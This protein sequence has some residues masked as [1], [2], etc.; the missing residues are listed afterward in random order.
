MQA[1]AAAATKKCGPGEIS[2]KGYT[3]K[4][5]STGATYKVA[6]TCIKD[7]G[8]PGKTPA[9]KKIPL[10]TE[11]VEELGQY[12]YEHIAALALE[13]RRAALK[14]AIKSIAA[15][16]GLSEHDAAVK[17][18]RRLN[19]LMILH[20]NTNVTLS[21]IIERDRNWVGRDYL[22]HQYPASP[23][24]KKMTNI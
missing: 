11:P 16:K 8:K 3:A 5:A 2:R 19:V 15:Q 1:A 10:G 7:H 20:K 14:R 4:R 13:P 21:G 22:G 24:R 23:R 18:M 6:R 12:G 9:A 17:V